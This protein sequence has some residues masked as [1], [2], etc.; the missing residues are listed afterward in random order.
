MLIAIIV[1]WV[2]L[3]RGH[4]RA[5]KWLFSFLAATLLLLALFPVGSLLLSP[6][7]TRFRANPDLPS[8][9][10]GIVVLGG[11]ENARLS[12]VW[13]QVELEDG[14]ERMLA[15]MALARRFPNAKLIFTGG[16]G[17]IFAPGRE[18]SNVAKTLLEQQGMDTSRIIFETDSRNTYE[19]AILSK[20]LARPASGEKWILIT[21][22]FHMPRSIGIFCQAGWPTIPY[23]VDHRTSSTKVFGFQFSLAGPNLALG[24]HEWL[25]LIAYYVTGKTTALLP[26]G[27][28]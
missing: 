27:C 26:A 24:V 18:D 21:S 17:T 3:M 20:R 23:P 13:N 28:T 19:S 7:E 22:A 14:A 10:D 11:S 25:G 2:F 8:L 12:A 16:S 1:I 9:V 15:F 4:I 6:L 5:T